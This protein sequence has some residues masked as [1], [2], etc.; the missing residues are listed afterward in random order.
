MAADA[1]VQLLMCCVAL[2]SAL[3]EEN[4]PVLHRIDAA[5]YA[6][7]VRDLVFWWIVLHGRFLRSN[8]T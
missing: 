3:V 6:V 8:L 4:A 1:V 5:M 2:A 7:E